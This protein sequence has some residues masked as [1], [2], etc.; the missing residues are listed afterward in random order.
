MNKSYWFGLLTGLLLMTGI[1]FNVHLFHNRN[2]SN[3]IAARSLK[4]FSYAPDVIGN[5][6][7]V[8]AIGYKEAFM[9]EA[10]MSKYSP[11]IS[12]LIKIDIDTTTKTSVGHALYLF[13]YDGEYRIY[14]VLKGTYSIGKFDEPPSLVEIAKRLIVDPNQEITD[15]SWLN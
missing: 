3:K 14:D 12:K 7:Y 8:A 10:Q 9:A 15:I 2:E 4:E 6:C 1:L 11:K 5:G 13:E